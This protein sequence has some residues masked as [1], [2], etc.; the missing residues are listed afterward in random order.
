MFWGPHNVG[1]QIFVPTTRVTHVHAYTQLVCDH[2]IH[3]SR[4]CVIT[5]F[6]SV[7]TMLEKYYSSQLRF[8]Y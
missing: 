5:V 4:C 8:S 2:H 7:F 3:L 6:G 1:Q